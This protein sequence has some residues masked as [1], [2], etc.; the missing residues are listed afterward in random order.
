V[1]ARHWFSPSSPE[2]HVFVLWSEARD[3][4]A[5]IL[6]DL[7]ERFRVLDVVEVVWTQGERF[8][9]SLSR[10][11]GDALPSG[12]D[13]ERHCGSGPFLVVVIEDA[14]PNY[15]VRRTSRGLRV[16]NTG[17]FDGRQRYRDWTGGGFR[18][19]ASDS[20]L[21]ADRNLRLLFGTGTDE[22]RSRR[23]AP[24]PP[25]QHPADP[26]GTDGW[27]SREQVGRVI[28]PYGG[29][30][31]PAA[32]SEEQAVLASD[33]WWVERIVG[34]TSIAPGVRLAQVAGAPYRFRVIADD[35]IGPTDRLP[36]LARVTDE[37]LRRSAD[38][39]SAL[40]RPARREGVLVRTFL[41]P[42]LDLLAREPWAYPRPRTTIA[43]GGVAVSTTLVGRALLPAGRRLDGLAL[44]WSRALS[45]TSSCAP[46]SA[47]GSTKSFKH[48]VMDRIGGDVDDAHT[49][50]LATASGAARCW[51]SMPSTAC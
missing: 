50:I 40:R 9:E 17:V 44:R 14:A 35:D 47:Q 18:V 42:A 45:P 30:L 28:E 19:H 32:P 15:G 39:A 23:P 11:Y 31:R 51:P 20:V 21:E 36:P 48:T 41:R 1:T 38:L 37:L 10:M 34:G 3:Q 27:E 5:R 43:V 2:V 25:R 12:S 24:G 46:V 26:V 29:V 8:A 13:K 4:E 6:A 49:W 7:A 22:A 33:P 16:V